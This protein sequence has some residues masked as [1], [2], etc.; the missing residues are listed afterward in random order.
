VELVYFRIAKKH[1][2]IDKP[3]ERSSHNYITVRGGG[4][5]FWVAMVLCF[6]NQL[7]FK[8]LTGFDTLFFIGLTLNSIISFWD[9]N[10]PLSA[11]IRLFIHFVSISCVF[12]GLG[13]FAS[14]HWSI[15]IGYI[16]VVGILNAYNFMDGING[17]TGLYSLVTAA[18]L[19]FVNFNI[20]EFVDNQF[21]EFFII[22]I[23]VFLF[24]NFRKHAKCFAGD[25]GSVSAAFI[26]TFIILQLI[27]KTHNINYLVFFA[28]YGVDSVLTIIHR[29]MLHENITKPHRK[30]V[31]Q[32]LANELKVPH[33]TVS[34]IYT[35]LQLVINAG[36]IAIIKINEQFSFL[37]FAAVIIL[38]SMIYIVI[39]KNILANNTEN[40]TNF[41]DV[42]QNCKYNET[43]Q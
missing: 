7:I 11:K 42:T 1:N 34:S 43:I 24:F 38:L 18:S 3:N 12:A 15:I 37:Y 6:I 23:F 25:V 14:F 9:D 30:H 17:I 40:Y 29:L 5:V 10:K 39:K 2:I 26:L 33:L 21:I 8:N 19:L 13:L 31:Y 27:V 22:S 35:G 41:Q 28:V 32:L 36:F 4:I 20:V 16:L